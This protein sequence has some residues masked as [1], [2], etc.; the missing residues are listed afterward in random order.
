M[1]SRYHRAATCASWIESVVAALASMQSR[2]H[3]AATCAVLCLAAAGSAGCD[4][5]PG[6]AAVAADAAWELDHNPT[7]VD[8]VFPIEEEVRRFRALLD[9]RADALTGGAGSRDE[10]VAR[11]LEALAAGDRAALAALAITPAEFIDLYYP[12]TRFTARPYELAPG[13]LWFQ[14]ENYGSRGLTRALERFGGREL[15]VSG[16]DCRTVTAEGPNRIHGGCTVRLRD[17]IR[18]TVSVS[19]F[20]EILERDGQFKFITLAGL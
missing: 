3:R 4:R 17:R 12:H 20:G 14:F 15:D 1:Q 19:L 9:H 6:S 5:V 11:Y 16:Y 7:H 8:S 13:L 18:G 10:L 2:Y